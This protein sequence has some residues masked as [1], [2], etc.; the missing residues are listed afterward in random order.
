VKDGKS[1]VLEL[2]G[3]IVPGESNYIL[4]T[5]HLDFKFITIGKPEIFSFDPR[6]LP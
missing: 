6:L 1:V 5:S 2:P 3:V 4:N